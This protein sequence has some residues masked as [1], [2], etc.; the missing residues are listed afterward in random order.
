M[1]YLFRFKINSMTH[2]KTASLYQTKLSV[3][4]H[5]K[6]TKGV[7]KKSYSHFEHQLWDSFFHICLAE[8]IYHF[9]SWFSDVLLDHATDIWT[10]CY[11][12]E[13]FVIWKF[14]RGE[15]FRRHMRQGNVIVSRKILGTFPTRFPLYCST[16]KIPLG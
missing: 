3:D 7:I 10:F 9:L 8:F 13:K 14:V 12:D 6:R 15:T 1:S 5:S 16:A 4:F 11:R 2:R